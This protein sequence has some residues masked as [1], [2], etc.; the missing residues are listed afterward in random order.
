MN[1][2]KDVLNREVKRLRRFAYSLTSNSADADDLVHDL[3]VKVLEQGLPQFDD[4]VPWLITVCKNLWLDKLRHTRVRQRAT[5]SF[6]LDES[7]LMQSDL[8]LTQIELS[9]VMASLL[10]LTDDQRIALSLVAIDGMSYSDAANLLDVPIGTIMSR[11]SRAR[12]YLL[13]Y[14]SEN[15][16]AVS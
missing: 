1:D 8:A 12:A 13:E 4:P 15:Q 6:I 10:H 5:E 14:F 16:G 11:V 2:V 9:Q 7:Q 3:V